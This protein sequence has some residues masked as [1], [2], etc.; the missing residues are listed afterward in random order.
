MPPLGGPSVAPST[1]SWLGVARE[2]T[3]G[4]P[5][6]PTNTI[7]MDPKSYTPEDTPKF[8]PDEAIRG[9][10]AKL[11]EDIIGPADATFSFGGPA[12]LD[13][14]G[15]F[16]DNIFGDLSTT[17]TLSA[18]TSTSFSGSPAVG[19]TQ[20]TVGLGTSFTVG[21]AVQ[22]DVGAIS[23]VVTLT[24][25]GASLLGFSGNP[26]RF[27]HGAAGTV[28]TVVAPFTHTFALLNSQLGYGGV[29]GAQPPTLTLTDNTNLNYGGTP[30]TNTSGARA[31]AS[32]CVSGVDISG[33]VEQLLDFKVKGN[34]WPSQPAAVTPTNTISNIIPQANWKSQ[35]YIGGT[36]ASNLITT[37]G[38]WAVNIKRQ[39]QVYWTSQGTISPYII[40][41]GPLDASLS[42]KF[43]APA[44]ETPLAYMRYDGPLWVHIVLNSGNVGGTSLSMTIDANTVQFTKSKPGRN[45]VLM[46]F[47]NSAECIANVT[48]VGGTGG[49][50]PV[51]VQLVNAL[52][53]Y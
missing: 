20:V 18:G 50:G 49:L 21:Q 13:T 16:L 2:L 12:F 48:N 41:R 52:P 1:R 40:A 28:F 6:A 17:G 47:D 19:A 37:N 25:T 10:M 4:T 30:G 34:S 38:E 31:Y 46:D 43:T 26:L 22:I 5:V 42:M 39:L 15:F 23:E 14:H 8:L 27:A 24:N 53:T 45:A 9:S 7:P 44:D 32:S 33:N 36:A 51:A 35:L 3:V 29:P 11:Y